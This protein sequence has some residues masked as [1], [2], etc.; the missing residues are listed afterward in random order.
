MSYS[1]KITLSA[2]CEVQS[3][4]TARRG[5]KSGTNDGVPAIQLR[6]LQ[7]E[8]DFDPSSASLYRL[9]PSFE[10]YWARAGDLLFRSRGERNTAVVINPGSNRAAIAILPLIVLRPNRDL[11]CPRYLAWFINRP[12]TQRYIGRAGS[13]RMR[14]APRC[15]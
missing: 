7:G 6:D 10:R 13:M 4:Y 5:L 12:E 9:E 14:R 2:I 8:D 3:G 1:R 11:V 15:R